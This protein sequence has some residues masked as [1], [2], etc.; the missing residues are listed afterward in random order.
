[1]KVL[2]TKAGG[3]ATVR[4]LVAEVPDFLKLSEQ[5][6]AQ[7]ATRQNEAVWEQRVRNLKSHDKT[8][9]NVIAEGFVYQ[10]R[11]G[12]YGLTAAGWSHL[13]HKGLA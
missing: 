7:S 11:R 9:G 6:L 13:K 12:R 8:P 2:A 1:M 5:D 4:T 3:E 10:V